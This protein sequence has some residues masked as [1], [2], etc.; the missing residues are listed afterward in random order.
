[1]LEVQLVDPLLAI[2]IVEVVQIAIEGVEADIIRS[3]TRGRSHS[4]LTN[5]KQSVLFPDVS[6]GSLSIPSSAGGLRTTLRRTRAFGVYLK[7]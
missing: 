4:Q 1:M 5:Q 6:H 2:T 3:A 7:S